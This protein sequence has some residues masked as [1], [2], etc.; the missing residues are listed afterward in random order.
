[1]YTSPREVDTPGGTVT[2]I[3]TVV[4]IVAPE[5]PAAHGYKIEIWAEPPVCNTFELPAAAEHKPILLTD[6]S[7]G[8]L[9]V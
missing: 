1:L 2:V 6:T 7:D 9:L 8:L 5:L 3:T 4:S